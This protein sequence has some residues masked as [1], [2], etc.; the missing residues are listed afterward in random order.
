LS[1]SE[2][3]P[4]IFVKAGNF[5]FRFRNFLFPALV[6]AL[7]LLTSPGEFAGDKTLDRI[8]VTAGFLIAAAGQLLRLTTIGFA[9]IKRGGKDRR[10]YAEGL[11][12]E[13]VY[14]HVRNP[15]YVGNFLIV[16]GLG[17]VYGSIW[18]Y[19]VLIPLFAF[20][21]WCITLAEEE[22]LRNEFGPQYR[23]YCEES[24]RFFVNPAA[25][26]RIVKGM[27]FDWR[28]ALR[29]EY[30]TF[31]QLLVASYTLWL[32]KRHALYGR[33]TEWEEF[34]V[35]GLVFAV[36]GFIY[37]WIRFLKKKGAL[38]SLPRETTEAREKTV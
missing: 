6:A 32:Y 37:V 1:G 33:Y 9:Y 27:R 15:M 36:L 38:A 17:T 8:A 34:L 18:S 3:P 25:L 30:G 4:H 28:K 12:T 11:V 24:N 5:F 29:K 21:Y 7:V 14:R 31:T 26:V 10:V 20:I 13:G 23:K 19:L 35:P 2:I 16:V 22:Y